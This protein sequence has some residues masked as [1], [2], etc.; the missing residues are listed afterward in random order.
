L[1]GCCGLFAA[2]EFSIRI[3]LVGNGGG[4]FGRVMEFKSCYSDIFHGALG[5][6][7]A[8]AHFLFAASECRSAAI[9]WGLAS[10]EE[11]KY[12]MKWERINR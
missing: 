6:D 11:A 2:N 9:G 5:N 8:R 12:R 10:Q 3:G 4:V 7:I 1:L